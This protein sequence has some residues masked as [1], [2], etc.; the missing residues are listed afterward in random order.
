MT[1]AR[2]SGNRIRLT[3]LKRGSPGDR[4]EPHHFRDKWDG[5]EAVPPGRLPLILLRIQFVNFAR[6]QKVQ[7]GQTT[8]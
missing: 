4:G 8:G 6:Q 5:T 1:A 3:S 2:V 7:V